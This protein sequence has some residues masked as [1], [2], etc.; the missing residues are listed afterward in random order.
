MVDKY[1]N[2][3]MKKTSNYWLF[4]TRTCTCGASTTGHTPAAHPPHH[5]RR[6]VLHR[7]LKIL[8]ELHDHSPSKIYGC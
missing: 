4:L 3:A 8:R 2:S 7:I 6:T 1:Q 5:A